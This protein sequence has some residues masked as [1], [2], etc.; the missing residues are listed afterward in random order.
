MTAIEFTAKKSDT[1]NIN[2]TKIYDKHKLGFMAFVRVYFPGFSIYDAEEIYNDAFMVTYNNIQ[3]GKLNNLTASLQTYINQV[4]KYKIYDLYK[5]RSVKVDY[6]EDIRSSDLYDRIDEVWDSSTSERRT[7]I[8]KFIEEMDDVRCKRIIFAY[9]YDNL[10]MD[11]IAKGMDMKT[12]DVAKTTKNRCMQ[13]IK[14][15]LSGLL[16]NKGI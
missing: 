6:F 4:G 5:K 15:V 3:S 13:K 8:Y 14:K 7:E 12:A 1:V 10:T 9:Y 11:A 2:L 16:M